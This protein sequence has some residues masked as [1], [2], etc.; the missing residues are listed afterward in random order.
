[1]YINEVDLSL[2]VDNI[3]Y[4]SGGINI[5]SVI[6]YMLQQ[7]FFQI[8]GV[9]FSVLRIVVVIIDGKLFSFVV[10]VIVVDQVCQNYILLIVVGVGN[11]V[12]INEFY[13][14]VD[15]LDSFNM[16]IVN[17]YDQFNIFIVQIIQKVC[18]GQ[19]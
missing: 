5:G 6:D 7:M 3:N 4:M 13:S 11:G 18:L 17:S 14:I 16:F 2:V 15:D 12:D 1:M 19:I 10:I 9:C 8:S